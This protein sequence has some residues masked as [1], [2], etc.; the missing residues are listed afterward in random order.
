MQTGVSCSFVSQ[1]DVTVDVCVLAS[2][3]SLGSRCLQVRLTPLLVC[4]G[5]VCVRLH[6][7]NDV[8]ILYTR[9]QSH[10]CTQIT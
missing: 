6:R 3:G 10:T 8:P 1:F 7:V 5:S 9:L 2:G 4:N